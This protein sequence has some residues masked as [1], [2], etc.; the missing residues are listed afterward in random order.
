LFP[1]CSARP[2]RAS[3][4]SSACPPHISDP[5]WLCARSILEEAPHASESVYRVYIVAVW[6]GFSGKM[7]DIFCS[8]TTHAR[9]VVSRFITVETPKHTKVIVLL[10]ATNHL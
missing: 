4:D 1:T 6:F 8:I 9:H 10:D 5:P 2:F 3:S 7:K